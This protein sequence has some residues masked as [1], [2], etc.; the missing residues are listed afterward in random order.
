MASG[1]TGVMLGDDSIGEL[2]L[3]E[4]DLP[5][6]STPSQSA[7]AEFTWSVSSD[8]EFTWSEGEPASNFGWS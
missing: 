6:S 2:A 3:A 5:T 8:A 7:I 1:D 4:G